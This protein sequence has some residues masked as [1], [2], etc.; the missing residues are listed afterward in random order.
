[1]IRQRL[2]KQNANSLPL[3]RNKVNKIGSIHTWHILEHKPM[4]QSQDTWYFLGRLISPM[5]ASNVPNCILM[6]LK[7]YPNIRKPK[8]SGTFQQRIKLT[9]LKWTSNCITC[10]RW[11]IKQSWSQVKAT[12]DDINWHQSFIGITGVSIFKQMYTRDWQLDWC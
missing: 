1:M 4:K 2:C 11:W 8:S 10:P 5:S 6:S 3:I 7:F 9:K 12:V